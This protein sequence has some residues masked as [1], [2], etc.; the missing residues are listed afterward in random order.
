M[1]RAE[2]IVLVSAGTLA[3]AWYGGEWVAPILGVTLLICGAASSATALN[4]WAA[5]HRALARQQAELASPA[6]E[7]AVVGAVRTP[8]HAG[9]KAS[10]AITGA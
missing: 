6:T 8:A 10:S 3:G 7:A 2:R 1:Q 5:A 4:R 9:Y